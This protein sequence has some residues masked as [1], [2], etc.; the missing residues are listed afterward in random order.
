MGKHA[1]EAARACNYRGAGTVEFLLSS[2]GSYYFLEMNTRLQVEHPVTELLYGLDLVSWQID[3]AEGRPLPLT[4]DE[5]D[6]RRRGA[7]IECRVYAEDP[8]RFLPSPGT[9]S[10]LRLPGG[11]YVRDD[12]GAYE[13]IEIPVHYDPLISKLVVWGGDRA[14]ALARM[15]RAL[16]EYLV[17]GIQT[18]LSFHRRVLR[19]AGFCA[20]EYDTGFIE[21]ERQALLDPVTPPDELVDAVVAAAAIA[22]SSGSNH[23]GLATGEQ[24]TGSGGDGISAWRSGRAGWRG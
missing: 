16:D 14:E 8:V 1:I 24:G 23:R 18:N 10:H 13:G 7:A 22:E 9:I 20:G 15:R 19:H 11:P 4:Q 6:A 17:R 12:S 5:L 2:D 3:V 21:R